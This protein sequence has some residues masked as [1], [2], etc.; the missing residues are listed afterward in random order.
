MQTALDAP[1]TTFNDHEKN[2]VSKIRK[3]GWFHTNVFADENNLGFSYTT[4]LWATANHPEV[5]VFSIAGDVASDV[6][7]EVY[8]AAKLGKRFVIG[9][10]TDALFKGLAAVLLP[11]AEV[12]YPQ[13]IL[14]SRW[15][16]GG[17]DFPCLQLVWPN[18][19]G[20]FPWEL[21]ADPAFANS[22]PDLS[23]GRWGGLAT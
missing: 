16:Y 10:P 20:R 21:D 2:L 18:P 11:M 7:A 4:G 8:D 23:A 15:F 6:F 14:L 1:T 12:H 19:S 17:E 3:L 22:Q 13:Y 5:I 9:E